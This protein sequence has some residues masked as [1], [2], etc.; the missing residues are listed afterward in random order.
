MEN[1]KNILGPSEHNPPKQDWN[2]DFMGVIEEPETAL[3]KIQKAPWKKEPRTLEDTIDK[4]N[5]QNIQNANE[6]KSGAEL[7]ETITELM[8]TYGPILEAGI[9]SEL[10]QN[11]L[12]FRIEAIVQ[13]YRDRIKA[14]EA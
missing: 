1:D 10:A 5:A 7:A 13:Q 8:K 2:R 12:R 9:L 14:G 11:Q 3:E 4:N 6:A